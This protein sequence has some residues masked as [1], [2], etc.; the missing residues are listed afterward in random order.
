MGN[1]QI[2]PEL[3]FDETVN[4]NTGFFLLQQTTNDNVEF[5]AIIRAWKE[6]STGDDGAETAKLNVEV[7]WPKGVPYTSPERQKEVYSMELSSAPVISLEDVEY[8]NSNC[9]VTKNEW[10]GLLFDYF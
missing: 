5:S 1:V 10:S 7:S 3:T 4:D 2:V 6:V 8:S 9:S